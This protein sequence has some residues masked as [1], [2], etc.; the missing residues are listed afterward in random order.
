MNKD[1]SAAKAL[2]HLDNY[3]FC[4]LFVA[5]P[6]VGKMFTKLAEKQFTKYL[7]EKAKAFL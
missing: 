1:L 2:I 4:M 5:W 3:L 6:L 7:E